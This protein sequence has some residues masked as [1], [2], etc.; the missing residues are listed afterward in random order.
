[1]RIRDSKHKKAN[2]K[3]S[4]KRLR[5]QRGGGKKFSGTRKYP[6]KK[7]RLKSEL[8]VIAPQQID[9]YKPKVHTKTMAFMI[10]LEKKAVEANASGATLRICFRN[11][12]LITAAA[13]IVLL[14][15]TEVLLRRFPTLKVK[16]TRPPNTR[17]K[18]ETERTNVVH[19]VLERI[20]FYRILRLGPFKTKSFPHVDNWYIGSS[21]Q[22]EGESLSDAI[23]ITGDLGVK[24]KELYRSGIE[25]ISNAVEHA[26]SN[27]IPTRKLFPVKKWWIFVGIIN[28]QLII[29][30]CDRGHGIPNTLP[31][32]QS[33][34]LLKQITQT[35]KNFYKDKKNQSPVSGDAFQ[36]HASTLVK[37][38][39]TKM[40]HRGKGGQDIKSFVTAHDGAQL[41]IFSN[42]GTY[43]YKGKGSKYV[44]LGYN[45][46]HS[47]GG[48]VIQW[49][50]P[51]KPE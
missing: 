35:L 29:L 11:T 46:H 34:S 7:S 16:I 38:T 10:N 6:D 41:I 37:E 32:T 42:K 22:V 47:I 33:E 27:L 19:A 36:I 20:G 44:E 5:S 15:T 43:Q 49:S 17:S 25:A 51:I 50:I 26:Y 12:S 24:T 30:V 3:I 31:Y 13:G 39:R 2:R 23:K 40:T 48:T 14:S 8:K 28:S 4:E 45:N 21:D 1:M 9:L 18:N